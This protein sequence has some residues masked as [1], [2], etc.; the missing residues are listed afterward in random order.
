M[1][2]ASHYS[3]SPGHKRLFLVLHIQQ[4]SFYARSGVASWSSTSVGGIEHFSLHIVYKI[5]SS[6]H[7]RKDD[8]ELWTKQQTK[9]PGSLWFSGRSRP[10]PEGCAGNRRHHR[11]S[12]VGVA[13]ESTVGPDRRELQKAAG[14]RWRGYPA[15]GNNFVKGNVDL[16]VSD[17]ESEGSVRCD[18]YCSDVIVPEPGNG[19]KI[20]DGDSHYCSVCSN[21]YGT[22]DEEDEESFYNYESSLEA[23]QERFV[24]YSFISIESRE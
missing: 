9:T 18:L 15:D 5:L 12:V 17:P 3:K 2:C 14:R 24:R 16:D 23:Y 13:Q 4:I 21:W 11:H 6:S 8:R 10:Q 7:R 22:N 19:E 1:Q 20:C